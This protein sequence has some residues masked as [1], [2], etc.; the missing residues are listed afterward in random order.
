MDLTQKLS[1]NRWR[2]TYVLGSPKTP[3]QTRIDRR[4]RHLR[5]PAP[6]AAAIL[7]VSVCTLRSY[8]YGHRPTP[9]WALRALAIYGR[10]RRH[11]GHH[12]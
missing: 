8:R 5:L 10:L 9:K 6:K 12:G 11:G 2:H 4:I 1:S 7:G 3:P